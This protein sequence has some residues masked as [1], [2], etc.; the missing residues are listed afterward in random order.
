METFLGVTLVTIAGL[1][2][3]SIAWPMKIMRRL[4][5]EHYW[6]V[7][8][9]GGLIIV[10]WSVVLLG[11]PDAFAAYAQVGWR[12]LVISNLFAIGWGVANVLYGICVV[13]IGAA[14]TGAMMTGLGMTVGIT[15]P[16]VF[17]GTGLFNE[18]PDLT[19]R[20]GLV[21]MAGVAVLLA[22]VVVSTLADFGRERELKG[23]AEPDRQAAGGFLSALILVVIAGLASCGIAMAF[24]YSQGPV[25]AAMKAHGAGDVSANVAVWAVGLMGGALI[26][27][28]YPAFVMSKNKSWGVLRQCWRDVGLG[29]IIGIQFIFA[30][31]L[32]G[33]GMVMLGPLGASIG[34]GIQQA[35]QIMG[36]QGVGFF[37]GEWRGV[38]GVPRS[39]MYAAIAI[40]IAGV[41]IL[42]FAQTLDVT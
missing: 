39:Q 9:L 32:L 18:A 38:R 27:V 26:N 35:M 3:G 17:K 29:A 10:P 37:S 22:G 41:A 31:V 20:V 1:G 30:V 13:R 11:C 8:M 21:V 19:S 33:R 5:F 25:V 12:P 2:T 23:K 6:F 34:F 14:L 7:G 15:L 36:N 28:L 4:E 40:L 16:M 24:V 42:A